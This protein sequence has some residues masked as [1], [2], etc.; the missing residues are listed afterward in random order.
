MFTLV[1]II[2]IISIILL[3]LFF[4]RNVILK[5]KL[6]FFN[7]KNTNRGKIKNKSYKFNI[8]NR[9]KYNSEIYIYSNIEKNYL[10]KQMYK[11]FK[12][13]KADKLEALKIAKKLSDRSTL[14]VL[15]VGLKDMDS[16]IVKIS[17]ELIANFK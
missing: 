5:A 13:S 15:R 6:K 9:N 10:K 2:L 11:L 12:G 3:L 7:F 14:N 16:D 17:A 8:K 4:K 1:S